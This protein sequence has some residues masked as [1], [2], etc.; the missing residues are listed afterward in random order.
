MKIKNF[1]INGKTYAAKPITFNAICDLED[2]GM[3]LEEIFDKKMKGI[4]VYLAYCGDM[5]VEAAGAEIEAHFMSG[6]NIADI[7]NAMIEAVTE[8]G[9]FHAFT[10]ETEEEAQADETEKAKE[11]PEK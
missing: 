1:V 7:S 9:F 2:M 3:P 6:K 4:R 5:D 10:A 11:T 8:S